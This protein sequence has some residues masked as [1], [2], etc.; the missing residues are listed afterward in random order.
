MPRWTLFGTVTAGSL[1]GVV[2]LTVIWN[3]TGQVWPSVCCAGITGAAFGWYGS[4]KR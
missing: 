3:L 4:E 2:V 1:A